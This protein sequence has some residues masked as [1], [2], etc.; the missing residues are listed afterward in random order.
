MIPCPKSRKEEVKK[1]KAR[2]EELERT[3]RVIQT[4]AGMCRLE[5]ERP[6]VVGEISWFKQIADK[7]QKALTNE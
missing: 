5:Y 2:I 7:A 6:P 3:L 1:L 4:W